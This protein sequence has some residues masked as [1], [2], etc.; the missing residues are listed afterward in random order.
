M[1]KLDTSGFYKFLNGELMFGK[2]IFNQAYTL[3]PKN[4]KATDGWAW[5]GSKALA[6]AYYGIAT[7]DY[8]GLSK[9]A[10]NTEL[11]AVE[12]KREAILAELKQQEITNYGT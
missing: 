3:S 12:K 10:L 2:N 1:D 9:E 11:V 8:S 7:T 5:F 4:M 6:E